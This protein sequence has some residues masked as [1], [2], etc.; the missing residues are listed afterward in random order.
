M[1][2]IFLL[3]C[4]FQIT[5]WSCKRPT[6]NLKINI[7]PDLIKYVAMVEVKDMTTRKGITVNP[8]INFSGRDGEF[9]YSVDG[10]KKF[11][12]QDGKFQIGIHPD[13]EPRSPLDTVKF[14]I[15]LD[16]GNSYIPV[17][18][19]VNITKDQFTQ[20]VNAKM[21]NIN[22]P[23]PGITVKKQTLLLNN[24]EL[25][26]SNVLKA[27]TTE[28]S[29][30]FDDGM[31]TVVL[32]KGTSFYYYYWKQ[33]EGVGKVPVWE[34]KTSIETVNG[35]PREVTS[36]VLGYYE[37]QKVNYYNYEKRKYTGD[38]I[39]FYTLYR[40][41]DVNY[42][43]SPDYSGYPGMNPSIKLLTGET[44]PKD[45]LLYKSAVRQKLYYLDFIGTITENGVSRRINISPDS[46]SKW[47]VS[48]V[49]DE[50]VIN[51]VTNMP[52]AEGDSVE[53]S[54]DLTNGITRRAEVKKANG[55]LR[56]ET[57]N[58]EAGYYYKAPYI[59]K[60]GFDFDLAFN[61]NDIPDPENMEAYLSMDNVFGMY[62]KPYGYKINYSGKI[63]SATPIT[64]AGSIQ[65]RYWG[66]EVKKT[67]LSSFSY[68][69]GVFTSLPYLGEL[70]TWDF[71]LD[72]GERKYK[73]TYTGSIEYSPYKGGYSY[74]MA[75]VEN[76]IWKTRGLDLNR[77]YHFQ[78]Y[79]YSP[80]GRLLNINRD[81]TVKPMNIVIEEL[82][83]RSICD[84]F[85]GK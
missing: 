24:G 41:S 85:E 71:T 48:Y 73:P 23:P 11:K 6:D 26:T 63:S 10:T 16:G 4:C 53:V 9:V 35:E 83:G 22:N 77:N 14:T 80:K 18:V 39:E 52:I 78:G 5:F 1:K 30:Y 31:T 33:V 58:I 25:I 57:Q 55:Q 76:G 2:K 36:R 17:S 19:E 68:T 3:A 40:S 13:I 75:R 7:N 43:V 84:E 51:P 42:A 37:E 8:K 15:E 45:E 12:V 67:P 66:L 27:K 29:T 56:L 49:L 32:P 20:Q 81:F 46:A 38:K 28:D 34:E 65:V 60:F 72:C 64:P 47:F 50:N 54:L 62:V 61:A 21:L 69:G 59:Y 44:V 74:F 79:G 82:E 70:T